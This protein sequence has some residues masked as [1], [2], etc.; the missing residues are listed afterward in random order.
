MLMP[1]FHIILDEARGETVEMRLPDAAARAVKSVM[2]DREI[3]KT[4]EIYRARKDEHANADFDG[5]DLQ[6]RLISRVPEL[7]ITFKGGME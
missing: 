7:A 4:I 6:D 5:S 1:R 3:A 2:K